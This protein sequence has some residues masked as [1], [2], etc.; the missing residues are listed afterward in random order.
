MRIAIDGYNLAMPQ[1]TGVATYGYGLAEAL[2]ELGH[3]VEGVFGI[4]VGED[5]A[6]KEIRF[7]EALGRTTK[8]L[9]G[10][11]L[12]YRRAREFPVNFFGA[13]VAPVPSSAFV[14]KRV[15]EKRLPAFDRIHTTRRL[16]ERAER[17]FQ[18]TGRFLSVGMMD[19]PDIMHWTYPL[20]LKL[21]GARNIYTLHDL[22]PLRLPYTTLDV[23]R[24]YH[25]LVKR[26]IAEADHIV[27]VSESSRR[28]I[29][30]IFG[31]PRGGITNTYQSAPMPPELSDQ[32]R[33]ADAASIEG[34]FGLKPQG[35]FLYFGAIEPKKNLGRLIE[36]YL[37]LMTETPLVIVGGRSWQSEDELKLITPQGAQG[38]IVS[39]LAGRIVRLDYLP[40]TLLMRLV[41]GAKAV[42]FPSLYEGFGLPVLEAM[43]LGV[44]VL[45]SNT[46]SLV[47]VA[48]NASVMVDPYDIRAIA[49]GLAALDSDADL[50]SRIAQAGGKQAGM[51]STRLYTQRLDEMIK[52]IAL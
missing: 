5:P 24:Y 11:A 21:E 13:R 17:Y 51:F 46:S 18:L 26:C 3:Q 44:P 29:E 10:K 38:G 36:A 32:D 33:A 12:L 8:P 19:P 39:R 47:E 28:D 6:L 25:A 27:T 50:R 31:T 35:Y 45:T 15:F 16:F 42:A 22:V 40:R 52:A 43:Q 14:E 37:S 34:I 20:P 49:G 30:Q 41:R 23:K 4:A 9:S 7:F 2:K 48:G 1:G